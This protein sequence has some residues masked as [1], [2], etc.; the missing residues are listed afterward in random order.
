[1]KLIDVLREEC[2]IANAQFPNKAEALCEIARAA[3]KSSILNEL[4]EQEILAGLQDRESLGSTGFGDG[5]AIPHCRLKSVR[6][7]VVGVV[8]VP[9]GV[10]FDALDGMPVRLIVFIVAPEA[11][12]DRHM[13]LLSAISQTLLIPGAVKE[14]L[15]GATAQAVFE[16]FVRHT[17]ADIDTSVQTAKSLF[18]IFIEDENVFREII[19]KLTGLETSSLVVLNT[20]RSAAYLSKK[21]LFADFWRDRPSD[22]G[23]LIK[24]IVQRGL[25]NETIRRIETVAGNLNECVGV[26]VTVQDIS[27]SAGSL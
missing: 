6:D 7:F 23:M 24:V 12:S 22:F 15:S 13:K 4:S 16:S 20:E 26:M 5:I 10:E 2:V 14:L 18:N 11:Q 9:S 1:M 3:M 8:T 25:V 17:R 19:E 27:Y 21:P